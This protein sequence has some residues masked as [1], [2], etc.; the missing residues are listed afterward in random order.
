MGLLAR[1]I[2]ACEVIVLVAAVQPEPPSY[3]SE[4]SESHR[5]RWACQCL[6]VQA[7]TGCEF[8]TFK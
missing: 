3:L 7:G 8:V 1:Y 4:S 5:Q 6:P 2:L